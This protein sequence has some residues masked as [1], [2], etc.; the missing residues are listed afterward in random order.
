MR[1]LELRQSI[2]IQGYFDAEVRKPFRSIGMAG[3]D[4]ADL[5]P[6]RRQ[7]AR[8]GLARAG[9]ADDQK[10][11]ARQRRSHFLGRDEGHNSVFRPGEPRPCAPP[12]T[13]SQ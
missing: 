6:A 13:S 2:R 7:E 5:L 12:R 9:E 10:W 3:I 1:A 4:G 8:R 11:P